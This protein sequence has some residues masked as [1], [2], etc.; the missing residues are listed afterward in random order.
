MSFKCIQN[1]AQTREVIESY[2]TI[3]IVSIQHPH[4]N[5]SASQS[6]PVVSHSVA[7]RSEWHMGAV[8][9][10]AFNFDEWDVLDC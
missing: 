10:R 5:N 4:V 2:L 3:T 6:G 1:C 7:A 9:N 8:S